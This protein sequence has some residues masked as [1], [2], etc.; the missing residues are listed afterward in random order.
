MATTTEKLSVV[1]KALNR[2]FAIGQSDQG[3]LAPAFWVKQNYPGSALI[4]E[5][6]IARCAARTIKFDLCP[7]NIDFQPGRG[8]VRIGIVQ[9]DRI[10]PVR[11]QRDR[12]SDGAV[13]RE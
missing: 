3:Q 2:R 7:F 9:P 10:S 6:Q 4:I 12:H 5:E 1:I 13:R 11:V 8:T